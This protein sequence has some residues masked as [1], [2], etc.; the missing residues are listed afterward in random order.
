MERINSSSIIM[1]KCINVSSIN[2]IVQEMFFS[3]HI[4]KTNFIFMLQQ[5]K[6]FIA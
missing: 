6:H 1:M 4:Q 2:R 5:I 3:L